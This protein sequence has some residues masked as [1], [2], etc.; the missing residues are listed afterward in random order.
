MGDNGRS[1][2]ASEVE[3]MALECLVRGSRERF[4]PEAAEDLF[5]AHDPTR[6]DGKHGEQAPGHWPQRSRLPIHD[7]FDSLV[8]ICSVL[9]MPRKRRE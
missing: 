5:G 2:S 8:L 9:V 3:H 1:E 6:R 7:G 4:R